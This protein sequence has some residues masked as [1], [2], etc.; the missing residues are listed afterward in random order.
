MI[1]DHKDYTVKFEEYEGYYS[2]SEPFDAS[3]IGFYVAAGITD[4]TN[5]KNIVEDPTY[6]E[7]VFIRKYVDNSDFTPIQF[8]PM[9]HR[10]CT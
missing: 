5:T 1:I 7:I 3:D 9:K 10:D 6:G 8:L 2:K 4:Y